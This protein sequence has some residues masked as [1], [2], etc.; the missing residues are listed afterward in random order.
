M[1]QCDYCGSTILIG[2]T[3]EG[4]RHYCG[5]ACAVN[6]RAAALG[7]QVP[8][9]VVRNETARLHGGP[10]PK[11]KGA[12]P[13]DVHTSYRVWSAAVLTRWS[14]HPQLCCRSCGNKA[15]GVSAVYS[16]VL[17]WWGFP[18]GL[19]MTPVQV[20]RNLAGMFGGPDPRTP[21]PQLAGMVRTHLASRMAASRGAA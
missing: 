7:S 2:G 8:S 15:R 17:G 9:E 11:C 1:A 20:V 3:R 21:S 6:G 14:S 18:W 19:L 13:V 12:G 16:L 5:S 4:N 10:C